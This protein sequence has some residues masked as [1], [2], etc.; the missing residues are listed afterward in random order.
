MRWL[1]AGLGIVVVACS[2]R[3]FGGGEPGMEPPAPPPAPAPPAPAP[4]PTC[5]AEPGP[6]ASPLPAC[7]APITTGDRVICNW[8]GRGVYY[9]GRVDKDDGQGGLSI[10][11]DDGDREQTTTARCL[12][13]P[14]GSRSPQPTPVATPDPDGIAGTYRIASASNPGG[15]SYTGSVAITRSGDVYHLDW[16]IA[17]SPG[18]VGVGL[19]VGGV[20][21]V[22]WSTSG[23]PGVVV[24]KVDGGKLDGRWAT[25][26]ASG[27]GTEVLDGPPGLSGTYKIVQGKNPDGSSYTGSVKIA[28]QGDV[29]QLAWS[30]PGTSYAG[31]GIL[32]GKVLSVGWGQGNPP[33]VVA[34]SVERAKL[35]GVWATPSDKGLG[36]ERLERRADP[37]GARH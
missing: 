8:M 3:V 17:G 25:G 31:I 21:G 27:V 35:D 6:P 28:K 22:G 10:Q 9:P 26:A 4:A 29:Y 1:V 24:Y 19:H 12:H 20:L 33:G 37:F 2:P 14:A 18:Y 36:K 15:S 32:K 16:T 5:A 13:E 23:A 34:Y 30:I 7:A 11:Y